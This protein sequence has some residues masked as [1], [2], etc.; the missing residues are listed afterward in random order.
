MVR[1][2]TFILICA[3]LLVA[4]T[5]IDNRAVFGQTTPANN[6]TISTNHASTIEES[7]RSITTEYTK[8]EE[9]WQA[10]TVQPMPN[11]ATT[12]SS[13]GHRPVVA[14]ALGGGGTRGAANIGVLRVL[15]RDKIPIDM[16]VGTSMGAI[17]GGLYCAGLSAD[18]ITERLE[19]KRFLHAFNTVPI[20]VRIALIPILIVPHIFGYHPYDGLYRGNKFAKYLNH[21]VPERNR[22]L[23]DLTPK[24]AAVATNL[25]DSRPYTITDGNLGRAIQASSAIPFL[26]R[27]VLIDKQLLVDGGVTAN[28]PVLQAKQLGADFVIG[29]D[30]DER[31]EPPL[32]SEHF[33]KIGSV[34]SRIISI[35]LAK[36]DES[37]AQAADILIHP[38]VTGITLLS[39]KKADGLRAISAGEAAAE[40]A[41]PLMRRKLGLNPTTTG[42]ADLAR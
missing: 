21:S 23:R 11:Q 2:H 6:D 10:T 16:I 37:Q 15:A 28:L 26:R 36:V 42:A 34:P 4:Q 20:P 3:C 18:Q 33:R 27:P 31:F 12:S 40:S 30:V 14:L 8:T 7:K 41:V 38:D 22:N 24:F 13:A 19:D 17:V 25:L 9:K 35:L 39:Y 32:P 1:K 5:I 29:V